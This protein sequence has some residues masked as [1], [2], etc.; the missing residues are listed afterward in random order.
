MTSR[1]AVGRSQSPVQSATGYF[2]RVKPP[3]RG[4]HHLLRSSVEICI[5]SECQSWYV[6]GRSLP[7]TLP[8]LERK[9]HR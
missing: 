4:V 5:P 2:P 1:S 6:T 7:L 9:E 8:H 3:G